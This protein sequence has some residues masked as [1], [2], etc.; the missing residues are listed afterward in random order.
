VVRYLVGVICL[1]FSLIV[2]SAAY[3]DTEIYT[4]P[5]GWRLQNYTGAS[6]LVADQGACMDVVSISDRAA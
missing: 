3:A 2:S 6:G 4:V 1:V 5:T